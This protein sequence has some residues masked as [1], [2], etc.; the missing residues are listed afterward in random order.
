MPLCNKIKAEHSHYFGANV[1]IGIIYRAICSTETPSISKT[2]DKKETRKSTPTDVTDENRKSAI[3]T[4]STE[5][6]SLSK[7]TFK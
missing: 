2:T 7:S 5:T 1:N 4:C 6:P 3:E